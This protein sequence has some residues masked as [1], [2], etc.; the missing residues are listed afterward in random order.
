MLTSGTDQAASAQ[1]EVSDRIKGVGLGFDDKRGRSEGQNALMNEVSKMKKKAR[2]DGGKE[3]NKDAQKTASVSN[4]VKGGI[5]KK[6][7][8]VGL[9]EQIISERREKKLKQKEKKQI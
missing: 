3:G 9:G 1:I 6:K 7:G 5:D 4:P 2:I 8:P